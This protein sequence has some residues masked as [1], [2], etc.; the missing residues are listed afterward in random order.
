MSVSTIFDLVTCR[1]VIYNLSSVLTD[2][3]SMLKSN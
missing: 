3:T 1:L 2:P